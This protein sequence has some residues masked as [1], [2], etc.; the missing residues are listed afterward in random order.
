MIAL[1]HDPQPFEAKSTSTPS[2][3]KHD[4]SKEGHTQPAK[5]VELHPASIVDARPVPPRLDEIS[6][7]F[8]DGLCR[9]GR[10]R[11]VKLRGGLGP[12]AISTKRD[13]RARMHACTHLQHLVIERLERG[14]S[15]PRCG[16]VYGWRLLRQRLYAI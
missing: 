16:V 3:R 9:K 15:K 13:A 10:Q 5:E 8:R 4:G 7:H 6:R 14:I 11:L 2:R 1:L 12:H